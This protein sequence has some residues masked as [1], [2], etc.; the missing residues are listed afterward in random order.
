MAAGQGKE[1]GM[2][3]D[4]PTTLPPSWAESLLRLILRPEDRDS[5]SGDLLEEYRESIVP[6]LGAKANRW[7][8]R[9]VTWYVLRATWAWGVL[10]AAICLWRYLLD[11][12]APLH[13]TPGVIA[14]RSAVMSWALI[15]TFSGCGAWHAWRTG[16]LRAGVLLTLIAAT[17]GGYLGM[18]GTLVSLAISH[19]PETMAAIEGS[20]GLFEGF[21]GVPLLLLIVAFITGTAGALAGRAAA[22]I[23]GWS[24]PNTKS[25]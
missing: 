22:E 13:Y 14:F 1:H 16:H 15:A 23:Y 6:A 25:A 19:G 5:V 17:L 21:P 12:L 2:T 8:V 11:T 7:Y 20:G 9:Q 3:I 18:A 10:V 24:R 4:R